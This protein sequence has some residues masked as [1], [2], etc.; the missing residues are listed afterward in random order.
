MSATFPMSRGSC[1][2]RAPLAI[3]QDAHTRSCVWVSRSPGGGSLP[4][5]ESLRNWQV[6]SKAALRTRGAR[7]GVWVPELK[8][9]PASV[10]LIASGC[11]DACSGGPS[12]NC[13]RP[14]QV[15]WI[16]KHNLGRLFVNCSWNVDRHKP[17]W[18]AT[19]PVRPVKR[20]VIVRLPGTNASGDTLPG[21][22]C[23][24]TPASFNFREFSRVCTARLRLRAPGSS[25]TRSG[26]TMIHAYSENLHERGSTRVCRATWLFAFEWMSDII[27]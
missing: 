16:P 24:Y 12:D 9:S 3:S 15:M 7:G 19:V 11:R 18:S 20:G 10:A 4:R 13:T 8:L 22:S 17:R 21:H 23:Q 26:I 14:Y 2:I 6:G 27:S 1:G 5:F 25:S